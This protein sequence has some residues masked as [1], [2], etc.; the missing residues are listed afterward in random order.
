MKQSTEQESELEKTFDYVKKVFLECKDFF[1]LVLLLLGIC[2]CFFI[3]P[4]ILRL[5]ILS[6]GISM[7]LRPAV[8]A[9]RK[10]TIRFVRVSQGLIAVT[11]CFLIIA[12]LLLLFLW[13]FPP[14]ISN[15]AETLSSVSVSLPEKMVAQ[16]EKVS[17]LFGIHIPRKS[18]LIEDL[19]R[20]GKTHFSQDNLATIVSGLLQTL[21]AGYSYS[22]A[23]LNLFL[24]PIFIF[25]ISQDWNKLNR[26]LLRIIP[27][28]Y[29]ETVSDLG[30][31]V[32]ETIIKY[33][34]AQLIVASILMVLY[35][36]AL[37]I[38]GVPNAVPI[39]LFSGILAVIPYAGLVVG[40]GT[41]ILMNLSIDPSGSSIIAPILA[42][43]IVQ[44]LEGNVITPKIMSE[45][46][47]L[48]PG[49]VLF[50]LLVGGSAFGLVGVVFAVP[51]VATIR[52]IVISRK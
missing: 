29:R 48:H 12:L 19:V 39:G 17:G 16:L 15:L 52:N 38:A 2:V 26:A 4:Q 11:S 47:G 1:L 49:V 9:I 28:S 3:A 7:L 32:D 44:A 10:K 50:S 24:V 21:F 33:S 34:K 51:A 46:T 13:I 22:L 42:F 37:L 8:L 41:A 23:I 6:Y 18:E 43:L 36:I 40:L 30:M 25:Y 45:S 20:Y 5:V 14:L 35:S 27:D 31:T